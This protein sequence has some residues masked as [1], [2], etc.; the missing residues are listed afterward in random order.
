MKNKVFWCKNCVVMSTRPRVT[1]NKEGLCSACQWVE[2]KR[3][4]D[5]ESRQKQ[6]DLLLSEQNSDKPFQCVTAVSGGKDGSYVSYNLKNNSDNERFLS[7]NF[8]LKFPED[9]NTHKNF[10]TE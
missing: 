10:K 2:E 1:F 3:N 9:H 6:L 7:E 8:D 4:I 5:W